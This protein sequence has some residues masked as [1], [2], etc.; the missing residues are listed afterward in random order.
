MKLRSAF[1]G[2]LRKSHKKS[3]FSSSACCNFSEEFLT[4]PVTLVFSCRTHFFVK[5]MYNSLSA[6]LFITQGN[7]IKLV[8]CELTLQSLC[9]LWLGRISYCS[10][11][12]VGLLYLSCGCRMD[13]NLGQQLYGCCPQGSMSMLV[14]AHQLPSTKNAYLKKIVK[15]SYTLLLP[16]QVMSQCS[17]CEIIS[18]LSCEGENSLVRFNLNSS[19]KLR[20]YTVNADQT[21]FLKCAPNG[22]PKQNHGQYFRAA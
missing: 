18:K 19:M 10:D 22:A 11:M 17:W 5:H 6:R 8:V 4:N 14:A 7:K 16:S 20:T 1:E 21:S 3:H 9:H 12:Q 2:V 15:P 13:G